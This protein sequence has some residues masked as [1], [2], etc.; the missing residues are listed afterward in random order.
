MCVCV[1]LFKNARERPESLQTIWDHLTEQ[2]YQGWKSVTPKS[3]LDNCYRT[4][5]C[6]FKECFTKED[7]NYE[8]KY[9]FMIYTNGTAFLALHLRDCK[10]NID[11]KNL[12]RKAM[13]SPYVFTC[14]L[15]KKMVA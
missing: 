5:L 12:E 10:Q 2:D 4:M 9:N 1:C 15:L 6:L 3:I 7:D 8:C 11:L 13:F 14:A